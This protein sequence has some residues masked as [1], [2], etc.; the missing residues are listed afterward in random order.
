MSQYYCWWI[1]NQ[2][3]KRLYQTK[4]QGTNTALYHTASDIANQSLLI[5]NLIKC[6]LTQHSLFLMLTFNTVCKANERHKNVIVPQ[7][8]KHGLEGLFVVTQINSKAN[9]LVG[10]VFVSFIFYFSPEFILL[11]LQV[12]LF[13]WICGNTQDGGLRWAS[14]VLWPFRQ[15]LYFHSTLVCSFVALFREKEEELCYLNNDVTFCFR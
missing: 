1:R 8:L 9:E 10:E 12:C 6:T 4:N 11:G 3:I 14:D 7:A 15:A 2:L 13:D 5:N